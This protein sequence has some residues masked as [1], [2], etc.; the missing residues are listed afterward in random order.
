MRRAPRYLSGTFFTLMSIGL[1]AL[2]SAV[3]LSGSYFIVN[4]AGAA[5]IWH[6][7]QGASPEPLQPG[8]TFK[9]PIIDEADILLVTLNTFTV[10]DLLVYTVDNQPVII[11]IRSFYFCPVRLLPYCIFSLTS[12]SARPGTAMV[13]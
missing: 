4:P 10:N 13:K 3:I 11:S 1:A 9:W 12:P 5:G 2:V 6:L 7:G 8:L